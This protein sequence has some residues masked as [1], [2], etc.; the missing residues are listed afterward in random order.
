MLRRSVQT[1]HCGGFSGEGAQ[2]PGAWASV[3]ES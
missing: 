3:A 1:S 2:A